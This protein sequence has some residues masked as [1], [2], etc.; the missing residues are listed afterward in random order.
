MFQWR[1]RNIRITRPLA[2]IG[3]SSL[4]AAALYLVI[5]VTATLVFLGILLVMSLICFAIKRIDFSLS[6]LLALVSA[7][8]TVLTVSVLLRNIYKPLWQYDG[9]QH[10]IKGKIVDIPQTDD[11]KTFYVLELEQ[12]DDKSLEYPFKVRFTCE[13][14]LDADVYDNV[15]SEVK[16]FKPDNIAGTGFDTVN[17]YLADKIVLSAVEM[18][19]FAPYFE[20]EPTVSYS[21]DLYD[22]DLHYY[23]LKLRQKVT[24]L[25]SE[26]LSEDAAGI[27]RGIMLGDKTLINDDTK[28]NF[29]FAGISHLLAVSGLHLSFILSVFFWLSK[30]LYIHR[31]AVNIAGI[32]LILLFMAVTGFSDSVVRAGVMCILTLVAELMVNEADPINSLGAAV[33]VI[34]ILNP[35]SAADAGLLLSV[36]ATFGILTMH[37]RLNRAILRLIRLNGM[38]DESEEPPIRFKFKSF[39]VSAVKKIVSVISITVSVTVTSFP[40]IA[41]T[42]GYISLVSAV[43]NLIIVPIGE[44]ILISGVIYLLFKLL[45]P[46]NV[47]AFTVAF[48]IERLTDL[49]VFLVERLTSSKY[50][51]FPISMKTLGYFAIITC[52]TVILYL[53]IKSF[54]K[55]CVIT[56]AMSVIFIAVSVLS[57]YKS[58]SQLKIYMWGTD[59]SSCVML[60]KNGHSLILSYD[61]SFSHSVATGIICDDT[62]FCLDGVYNIGS[63]VED[64]ANL[65]RI[66]Q[67]YLNE[68]ATNND[69]ITF[70]GDVY[71][72]FISSEVGDSAILQYNGFSALFT[73]NPDGT[74]SEEVK[75][76]YDVIY[77]DM[78]KYSATDFIVSQRSSD[79]II[80][81]D[82][83]DDNPFFE[84]KCDNLYYQS[85]DIDEKAA[86][87]ISVCA[88]GDFTVEEWY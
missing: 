22:R 51:I 58:I 76:E 28:D 55:R 65:D 14:P 18:Q 78:D 87:L 7:V 77:A 19:I 68:A 59:S 1:N 75:G 52:F 81:N 43:S 20:H 24:A 12:I 73:F 6:A 41:L 3:L 45:L 39:A 62:A 32:G 53:S 67:R 13:T 56:C 34:L 70:D 54:G 71:I 48:V 8:I 35:F 50:C 31:R 84:Q 29:A 27:L 21:A 47:I 36:S 16:L 60:T 85:V 86:N 9:G 40:V 2:V 46:V 26:G 66:A 61:G 49:T 79:I 11:E 69:E 5:D 17:Y 57:H 64:R 15:S 44:M 72:S 83:Y 82:R 38:K 37:P 33:I 25:I 30:K 42:Y 10:I 4:I 80:Y 74:L 23:I 63:D 88:N